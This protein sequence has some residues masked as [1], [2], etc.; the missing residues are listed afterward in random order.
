MAPSSDHWSTK[1]QLHLGGQAPCL[2]AASFM[3]DSDVHSE[4]R[5]IPLITAQAPGLDLS[6]SKLPMGN[7]LA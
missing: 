1:T 4:C 6:Q 7:L 3:W 5:V 2:P